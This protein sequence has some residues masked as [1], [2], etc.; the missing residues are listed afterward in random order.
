MALTHRA[1]LQ[2][3][4]LRAIVLGAHSC[5]AARVLTDVTDVIK[6]TSSGA[7]RFRGDGAAASF[8]ATLAST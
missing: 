1:V 2:L 7:Q 5:A 6:L 8:S 3:F 4:I